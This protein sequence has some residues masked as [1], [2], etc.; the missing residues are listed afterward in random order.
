M[1]RREVGQITELR[2]SAKW[3]SRPRRFHP[4]FGPGVRNA[5]VALM[6]HLLVGITSIGLLAVHH[7]A[8]VPGNRHHGERRGL[9]RAI[10]LDIAPRRR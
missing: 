3:R 1:L 7:R 9:R 4:G 5:E 10:P 8:V 6:R 2:A